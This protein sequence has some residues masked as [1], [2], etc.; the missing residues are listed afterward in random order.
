MTI[1]GG[2]QSRVFQVDKGVTA[3]IS[4]VTITAGNAGLYGGGGLENYGTTTLTDCTISGNSAS[5]G[6]GLYNRGTATLTDCTVSGNSATGGN[7]N[8]KRGSGGGLLTFGGTTTLTNCTVS[9]NHASKNGGGLYLN[10]LTT[11]GTTT[12]TNCTVSGNSAG[13][14]GGVDNESGTATF[15]NTIVAENTATTGP[16]AYGAF[17]S[18]GNNLIG[19]TNGSSGWVGSDLTG[20]GAAPLEAL[21]APL[22]H[23]GGP[24]QTMA[25]LPGSPA[26]GAGNNALIPAGVTTDQR[27]LPRIESGHVDIGAFESSGFTLAYTS[28]SGQT[29][30]AFA[31][32]VVT[33]AANN[34]MEPV[35]GGLVTFTPPGS[36]G[37]S[38]ELTGNPA[39]ISAGGTASVTATSNGVAGSDTVSATAN[40]AAARPRSA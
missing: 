22:G 26:F 10:N 29:A 18:R 34:P 31:P 24:T 38:A 40:G 12:L 13:S 32:L 17:T 9:G 8:P 4:G 16:D 7:Y 6:G 19:E 5:D 28:G 23:Y 1:S 27:G 3:S 39:T 15:G 36:G 33:V 30:G 21:L 11:G 2:G 37:A 20:T 25:L 35:A 14:G